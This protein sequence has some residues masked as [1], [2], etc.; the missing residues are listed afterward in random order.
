MEKITLKVMTIQFFEKHLYEEEM[1]FRRFAS[2]WLL[3]QTSMHISIFSY[4]LYNFERF[5]IFG[6]CTLAPMKNESK[7]AQVTWTILRVN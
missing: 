4:M 6:A 7:K 2:V 1:K 3:M 5:E